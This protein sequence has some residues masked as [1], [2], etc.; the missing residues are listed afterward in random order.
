MTTR[1]DPKVRNDLI[2]LM[3]GEPIGF[4]GMTRTC[5]VLRTDERYVVK[6]ER[7]AGEFFSNVREWTIWQATGGLDWARKW[8]AMPTFIS[9]NGRV[10]IMERTTPHSAGQRVPSKLPAWLT[11]FK[12]ENYGWGCISGNFVC[13]DYASDIVTANSFSRRMK[14]VKWRTKEVNP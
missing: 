5:F 3:L 12:P 4:E 10:L 14:A 13:H 7:S 11:D 9:E 8:L 6:L 1:D 2:D